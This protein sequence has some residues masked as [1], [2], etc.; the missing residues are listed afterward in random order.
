MVLDQALPI[1]QETALVTFD[2]TDIADGSGNITFHPFYTEDVN[3]FKSWGLNSVQLA[4]PTATG[5]INT[6]EENIFETSNF[7]LPKTAKGTAYLTGFINTDGSM[8]AEIVKISGTES[9]VLGNANETD[10]TEYSYGADT[11]FSVVKTF[12]IAGFRNKVTNVIKTSNG[13]RTVTGKI[14]FYHIDNDQLASSGITNTTTSTSYVAKTYTNPHP[15]KKLEKIEVSIKISNN[16]STAFT[17]TQVVFDQD[18]TGLT[19][20]SM[21]SA[22]TTPTYSGNTN[23]NISIPLTETLIKKGERLAVKITNVGAGYVLDPLNLVESTNSSLK[24]NI[25]FKIDL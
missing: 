13:T 9:G 4:V 3:G 22:I 10:D 16:D 15:N 23:F 1:P 20:T 18:I 21:S 2:F 7:N 19:E 25:P 11:N 12:T 14:T 8:K 5:S 6:D 24:L 17:D